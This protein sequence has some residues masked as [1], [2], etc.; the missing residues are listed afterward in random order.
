[1]YVCVCVCA[2]VAQSCLTLCNPMD[3]SP[4]VLCPWDS[5]RKNTRVGCHALIQGIFP[6]LGS[7]LHL[8]CLL[9]WQSGSLPLS[10]LGREPRP[11][12]RPQLSG[13]KSVASALT[14]S[15]EG[16]WKLLPRPDS[17]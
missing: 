9:H 5:P 2:N 12:E 1:M 4:L 17:W 3:W 14:P 6:I 10:H 13:K 8:L 7:D 16:L 11:R 15:T